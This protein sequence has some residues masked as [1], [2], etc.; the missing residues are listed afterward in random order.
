M[1]SIH[2]FGKQRQAAL[3][4]L[5]FSFPG[6]KMPETWKVT[7]PPLD[8]WSGITWEGKRRSLFSFSIKIVSLE[9]NTVGPPL[10]HLEEP[11]MNCCSAPPAILSESPC[12]RRHQI[13]LCLAG[14]ST[15]RLEISCIDSGSRRVRVDHCHAVFGQHLAHYPRAVWAGLFLWFDDQSCVCHISKRSVKSSEPLVKTCRLSA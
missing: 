4:L 9:A 5:Q 15:W 8:E 1:N 11:L 10:V 14:S 7:Y 3:F 13:I 6:H 2:V 12:P